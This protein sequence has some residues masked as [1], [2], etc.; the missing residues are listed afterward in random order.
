MDTAEILKKVRQIEIQTNKLVSETFA[1]EYLSTF[2]GQGIEFSEVR[3]YSP[4][5]DVRSIDWNV[6]ARTGTPFIKKFN[7]E[8]ELTVFIACDVSGSGKFGSAS[9]LKQEAAAE[10]AALFAFSALHNNDK[11]GL[12]LFSDQVELF[13]PPRKGRKHILRLIRELIAFEPKH[14]KTDIGLC[15]ETLLKVMKHSG[16][17]I[18]ISDFIAPTSSFEK[19]FKLAAKKFD[20]IPVLLQ[21]KLEVALPRLPVCI[22]VVD[23]ETGEETSLSLAESELDN[24]LARYHKTQSEELTRLFTP[25]KI[26]PILIDTAQSAADPVIAFFKQRAKKVRR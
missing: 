24:A 23:P 25:Y 21:D 15:L 2:K 5:D 3:E 7:E 16:I 9:K 1:G 22:D 4:G 6:T 13:L 18:L 12:L 10:L 26:E 8:R 14:N 19:P 17:L 11:V 20:L